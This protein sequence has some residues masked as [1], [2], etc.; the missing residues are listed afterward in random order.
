MNNKYFSYQIIFH[1]V[2]V[3]TSA[4][5][6]KVNSQL[7]VNEQLTTHKIFIHDPNNPCS[8]TCLASRWLYFTK[9]GRKERRSQWGPCLENF[10]LLF[11]LWDR[12][13]HLSTVF[14]GPLIGHKSQ[15]SLIISQLF[16]HYQF[17]RKINENI[18]SKKKQKKGATSNP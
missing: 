10:S 13:C 4:C 11:L 3:A 18:I 6:E 1:N 9:S 16:C 5:L 15:Q 12:C 17:V 14:P 8:S 7:K 2:T